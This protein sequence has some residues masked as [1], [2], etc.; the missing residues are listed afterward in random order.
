MYEQFGIS[1][2]IINLSKEVEK[3]V[4]PVFEK[5]QKVCE[6]NSLKVA[7][8]TKVLSLIEFISKCLYPFIKK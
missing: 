8:V 3:E 5:I 4:E 7:P 6:Y 2:K 1:E